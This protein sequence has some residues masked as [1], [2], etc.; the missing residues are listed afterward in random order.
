MSVARSVGWSVGPS[1][2]NKNKPN[3]YDKDFLAMEAI[4]N[5][6]ASTHWS[7]YGLVTA[8]AQ[9]HATDVVVYTALLGN[10]PVR[11]GWVMGRVIFS[12]MLISTSGCS[13]AAM[14]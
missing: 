10:C 3:Q 12:N 7:V 1:R 5:D 2:S 8:P 14:I 9:K 11:V 4:S 6:T 13:N